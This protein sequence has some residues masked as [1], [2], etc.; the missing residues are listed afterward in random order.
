M[1]LILRVLF[2]VWLVL[3]TFWCV[4]QPPQYTLRHY[5][6]ENGLPQNSVAAIAQ[7]RDGFVWLTTYNGLVRFDGQSFLTFNKTE[8][9]LEN[10]MFVDFLPGAGALF[11]ITDNHNYVKIHAGRAKKEVPLPV[12][13]IREMFKIEEGFH[14]LFFSKGHADRLNMNWFLHDEIDSFK[15][16][17]FPS[18]YVFLIPNSNNDFF[19]WQKD[20]SIGYY[21]NWKKQKNYATQVRWPR[22]IFRIG[23]SL[24]NDDQ[25]GNIELLATG[26]GK[27]LATEKVRLTAEQK[28]DPRLDLTEPY[29][30]YSHDLSKNA[31]IYQ[32]QKLFVLSEKHPGEIQTSL[33]LNDFDFQKNNVAS[34]F[35]DEKH[36]RLFLGTLS[37]GLFIFDF[38]AF[39][40]LTA[41]SN[42]RE[43][44]VYYAQTAFSDSSV[45]TPSFNVLGK[46]ATG[47]TIAYRLRPPVDEL[48][49]NKRT[50][51]TDRHGDIWCV[52]NDVLYRFDARG[53]KLK[54]Q[55][56][57]GGE[58]SHIYEDQ[59][60]RIWLGTRFAGLRYIDP[61]E[62]GMPVHVFTPKILRITY[63]LQEGRETLWVG[64]DTG[65][66][67]VN[68][69]R[70]T[71]SLIPNTENIFVKN[72]YMPF[73]GELWFA[74][75]DHGLC[76][77]RNDNLTLFPVDKNRFMASA[78]CL[79]LDKNG[80]FWM[81]T[82]NGLFRMLR[83]DLL[84]YTNHRDSTRLYYHRYIRR[85]GLRIDEFNGGC[86]P[87]AVRLNNGYVS[88]PSL[89]GLVF[90]K[91]E[92]T[93]MDVPD[94]KIFI[95]RV[96]SN[97]QNVPLTGNRI[98]LPA[99]AT[100]LKVF[101][102]SPYLGN[103]ENQQLFYAVSSDRRA[104]TGQVW[105]PIENEQQSI[106]LNNLESGTYTLRIRK[107]AGFGSNAERL[108]T[109]T[110]LVPYEW[111]ETWPFKMLMLVLAAVAVWVYFKNRLKKADRL[112]RVLESRV[113][114]K[115][116]DLQDTL[117]ALKVSE[118]ELI[119]QIR[120]QMHLIGSIS[121]DIRSPLRSIQFT[122]SQIPS[123][124][125]KGEYGLAKNVGASVSESSEKILLLLE[126]MLSYI[127]SQVS[128]G[129]VAFEAVPAR[130]LVD[131]VATIFKDAFVLRQNTFVNNVPDSVVVRSNQQLL[132][133][134][135]HNLI[136]NA[137]KFTYQGAITVSAGQDGGLTT[138]LV[139][140]TGT[141]LPTPVRNWLNDS[142]MAYPESSDGEQSIN[143]IGLMIVREL[144]ELLNVHVRANAGPGAS[145]LIKFGKTRE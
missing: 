3:T 16:R 56:N 113:S 70:K 64:A 38:H 80:Y 127:K 44:N 20:G 35:F 6:S 91:P 101:I 86:Q 104:E 23:T 28:H 5:T 83:N 100:D 74:T 89:D 107:N 13:R 142:S 22:G 15:K 123:L 145:F 108:T 103:R 87:C 32:D 110:V 37:N 134:I 58:I 60:G 133:I 10:N 75:R 117:S 69:S 79:I 111:Y 52:R 102:S 66:F 2:Q 18:H 132:K 29:L 17:W 9:G 112:N 33:L 92:Q 24:Y 131:N 26:P 99:T 53:S 54:G 31:F 140:D 42:E 109:L 126:N 88:M 39:E 120:L 116:R 128:G 77:F 81:S 25:A 68:L 72:L 46:S 65:L 61:A 136:D 82:N 130:K 71:F 124:I 55:L 43:A 21:S 45:I 47:K 1:S 76:L 36:R 14:S 114:E 95:D 11:A 67:R 84:D 12:R 49:M 30:V 139:S 78:H 7:D 115:T 57:A 135:L 118:Q 138:L 59:T 34:V 62:K 143:G 63:M 41:G 137:N 93:P 51:L 48:S 122:S 97:S 50:T 144:A 85:D 106:H 98:E 27:N 105:F 141:D 4:A 96:E 94:S 8:L 73:K 125:Q 19:I 121:H 119:K 40:T 90:F 129:S